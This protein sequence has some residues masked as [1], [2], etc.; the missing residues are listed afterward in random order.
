MTIQNTSV[1]VDLNIST[2]TGRKLDKKVSGE[3]DASKGTKTRAGNY[4]KQLMAGTD[5]LEE[6]QKIVGAAPRADAALVRCWLT[7]AADG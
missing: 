4:H 2:W 6:V 7:P 5:K 1:L 3:I